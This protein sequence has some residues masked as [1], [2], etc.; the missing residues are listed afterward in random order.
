MNIFEEI[1]NRVNKIVDNLPDDVKE[2][3]ELK[4]LIV[5]GLYSNI[6]NKTLAYVKTKNIKSPIVDKIKAA[7]PDDIEQLNDDLLTAFSQLPNDEKSNLTQEFFYSSGEVIGKVL[8]PYFD[9][10]PE[11]KLNNILK[12]L[13]AS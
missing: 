7:K 4:Q 1:I 13:K 9:S 10:L 5:I 6:V 12:L 11:D 8:K 2:K 3:K